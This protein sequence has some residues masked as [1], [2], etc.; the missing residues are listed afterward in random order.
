M[1]NTLRTAILKSLKYT[2]KQTKKIKFIQFIQSLELFFCME[3]KFTIHSKANN[4]L[5]IASGQG[6]ATVN[7]MKDVVKD[8]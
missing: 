2:N 1:F 8:T 4:I 5:Y 6:F 7:K 3:S